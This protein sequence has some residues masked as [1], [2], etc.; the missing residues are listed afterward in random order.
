MPRLEVP[1]SLE[2][3]LAERRSVLHVLRVDHE[4]LVVSAIVDRV[5][6]HISDLAAE[7]EAELPEGRALQR[8]YGHRTMLATPLLREGA[9]LGAIVLFRLEVRL[10][11][12]RQAHV[13]THSRRAHDSLWR[14]E[15]RRKPNRER[16]SGGLAA[17]RRSSWMPMSVPHL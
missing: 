3:E 10:F 17:M 5:P 1:H 11:S 15:R 14:S 4:Q 12:D 13:R 2:V 16:Q 6:I 9:A 7:S 8:V